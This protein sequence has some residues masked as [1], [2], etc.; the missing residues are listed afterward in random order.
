[1]NYKIGKILITRDQ[2]SARVIEIAE[3]IRK[4]FIE[5]NAGQ[6]LIFVG[7]LKGSAIFV[8]DLVRAVGDDIDV[9]MDFM[10]LS[11]YGSDTKSSGV[12]RIIKD[13][14]I[15]IEGKNV[16]I[17]ED[18]IDTGLTMSYLLSILQ[19]REP[20]SLKVCSLLN[21][22]K[23]RKTHVKIDYCGFEIPDEFVIGYGLDYSGKWR[24]L[25]DICIAEPV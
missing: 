11:S 10:A 2:I 25:S 15:Y 1:M 20:T 4:D 3:E 6:E 9:R 13:L 16:I 19:R 14:D 22:E 23:R 21:K 18:I 17:V 12:V 24:H 7:I 5:N 8:A